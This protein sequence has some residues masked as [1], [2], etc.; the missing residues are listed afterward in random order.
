[1]KLLIIS[2]TEHYRHADGR[3]A[4]WGP[5]VRE[6][7]HLAEIFE[8]IYHVAPLH[9][10][11]APPSCMVYESARIHFVSLHPS[12]G[13]TL[14]AKAGILSQAPVT[15]R[16]VMK[17]LKKVDVFQFRGPTGIGVYLL[18]WLTAFCRKPGW[19]KYAG[20]WAQEKPPRGYAFQRWWLKRNFMNRPVTINGSWPSQSA[21]CLTFENPCLAEDERSDGAYILEKKCYEGPLNFCF[22]GRLDEAKGVGR[23][24][25]GFRALGSHPRIGTLHFVGDG[26]GRADYEARAAVLGLKVRFHGFLERKVVNRIY[27]K[28]HVI[29]LFSKS[30]GFPKAVAEAANYGCIPMV[31]NVGSLSQYVRNGENGFCI[32]EVD[33]DA[34]G[35]ACALRD[36]F[37]LDS[38]K[39]LAR[40][41]HAMAASF[42]F[43]HYN[44]RIQGEIG[45]LLNTK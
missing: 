19:V 7:N 12:G 16:T 21:H 40:E 30:E 24:L 15:I 23:I 25:E 45:E 2:H 11:E 3:I 33:C 5:T 29:L 28:S 1:M 17:T 26:P 35:V 31:S 44:S 36:L 42:T 43:A 34:A 10:G 9:S 32:D 6:I 37:V 14:A 22:V 18:P 39:F 8:E 38:P 27:E 41:A 4:G 20:N 13:H